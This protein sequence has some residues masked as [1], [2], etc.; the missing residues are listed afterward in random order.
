MKKSLSLAITIL[1]SNI[2]LAQNYEIDAFNGQTINTCSG[3]FYDSGGPFGFYSNNENYTITFCPTTAGSS[4]R[5]DFTNF[6]L[7]SGDQLCVFDGI[8]LAAPSF[9][10][11]SNTVPA[12]A[13]QASAT[14]ASGCLT[15]SYTSDNFDIS[16]GWAGTISCQLPC[17][18]VLSQLTSSSPVAVPL[19]DGYIDICPGKQVN[20]VGQGSYPQNNT[21]YFQQDATSTFEWS[22]EGQVYSGQNVSYAFNNPGGYKVQLSITDSLGCKSTNLLNQRVRVSEDPTF[23]G[24][25]S[26]KNTMCIGDTLTLTGEVTPAIQT[27]A[28]PLS[29]G[30]SIFLPDGVGTCYQTTLTFNDFNPGQTLTSLSDLIDI[31]VT[32][33][34]SYLGDLNLSIECPNGNIVN[35]HQYSGGGGTFLGEPIDIDTDLSPGLGYQYCFTPTSTQTWTQAVNV[36]NTVNVNGNPTLP[37]GNYASSQS[38]S[39]L[40]GCPLN[41]TWEIEICDNLAIDNGYIFSWGIQL[42]PSVYPALD[43][44]APPITNQQWILDPSSIIANQGDT[45]VTVVPNAPGTLSYDFL[46]TNSFGCDYDTTI[47]VTILPFTDPACFDCDTL[48]LP[49]LVDTTICRADSASLNAT[50]T[51]NF[52]NLTYGFY[53]SSV[54]PTNSFLDAP[55]PVSGVG[56]TTVNA[57]TIV[58]VC[59]DIT[60]LVASDIDMWLVAPNGAV[61]ELSTDNGLAGGSNY[62]NTCFTA[63]ATSNITSGSPPFTGSFQPEGSWSTLFGSAINGTWFLRVSDDAA[64]FNGILNSVEITFTNPYNVNY[65]WSPTNGLSCSN[66]PNPNASPDSTTTYIVTAVDNLGCLERDTVTISVIQAAA[67][68][69]ITCNS[70]SATSVEVSW[71]AVTNTA[72]YEVNINNGGW[73]PANGTLI[74]T[75]TGL[76]PSTTV[77]IQV[78]GIRSGICPLSSPA[79]T[80]SCTS[81]ACDLS[82][83]LDSVQNVSCFGGNNG[84]AYVNA[85]SS[86]PSLSYFYNGVNNNTGIFTNLDSSIHTILVTD[87]YGCQDSIPVTITE[88]TDVTLSTAFTPVICHGDST[89]TATATASG[90]VGNYTYQWNTTPIQTTAIATN[91]SIGTYTVTVADG[92]NCIET[93]SVTITEP[94]AL[95]ISLDKED[96]LCFG[97]ND[98][99]AWTTVSGGIAPYNYTWNTTPTQSIDT[100]FNLLKGFHTVTAMDANNCIIIDSIL[101]DEPNLLVISLD[102][103]DVSCFNAMDG[104]ITS[105][106]VGG[107]MPYRYAW[108]TAPIQ[109]STAII[110]ISGGNYALMVTD[111]NGCIANQSIIVNEPTE[112]LATFT[113]TQVTC[114]G[115]SDGDATVF[116]TGGVGGYTYE[117]FTTP[118]QTTVQALNLPANGTSVRITDSD[119]C[120]N[121]QT[122]NVFGPVLVDIDSI[123]STPSTCYES[124]NGSVGSFSSGGTGNVS[125]DWSN[126]GSGNYQFNLLGGQYTLTVT[127]FVGCQAI[128][129]I[130]V[131]RPD[132]LAI[133]FNES[134]LLC[135]GDGTGAATANVT[136]GTLPYLYNW[137]AIAGTNTNSINNLDAGVYEIIIT[138]AQNCVQRDTAIL[139]EPTPL[140]AAM[141]YDSVTC[142]N[143]NDGKIFVTASG[144]TGNYTYAW[145]GNPNITDTL[146]NIAGGNY[147][148]IVS[149][150]NNCQVTAVETVFEPLLLTAN[151]ISVPPSCTG[152]TNGMA[153]VIPIGGNEGYSYTWNTTP[154]QTNDTAINLAGGNYIFTITDIK[155]CTY[156]DTVPVIEPLPLVSS[157]NGTNINCYQI[158]DGTAT[159]TPSDGTAPY[160]YN[161]NTTT[162]TDSFV[163]ALDT[164]WH[165]VTIT[166]A[167]G[168]LTTDS[169]YLIEPPVLSVSFTSTPVSCHDGSD[170]TGTATVI[171]GVGPYSYLW[172]NGNIIPIGSGLSA[173]W[174]TV[175]ITDANNCTLIDSVNISEP[176]P[177]NVTFTATEVDCYSNSTGSAQVTPTGGVGNYTYQWNTSPIQTVFNPTNLPAG[178]HTVT[179][180]DGNGCTIVDSVEVIQ[181]N[182][183]I[184][185]TFVTNSPS[186]NGFTDGSA[187]AIATGGTPGFGGYTYLWNTGQPSPTTSGIGAGTFTVTVTDS[188]GC[189]FVNAVTIIEPTPIAVVTSQQGA[190]CYGKNDASAF[191]AASGGTPDANNQYTY[192]WSTIP[193]QQGQQATNL[194]GGQTYAVTITDE[195][196]CVLIENITINHPAPLVALPTVTN[197]LCNESADGTGTITPN[198]GTPPYQYQWDANANNQTTATATG[199]DVG[200]YNVTLTDFRGCTKD[201]FITITEPSPLVTSIISTDNICKNANDGAITVLIAGG[202]PWYKYDWDVAGLADTSTVENLFAGIYTV[203]VTDGNGCEIIETITITEPKDGISATYNIDDVSCFGERDGQIQINASGDT[204]PF[205]FSRDGV[206]Y[207]NSNVLIGLFAGDYEVFVRDNLGCIFKDTVNVAQ[208]DELIVDLG[209][210]IFLMMGEKTPIVPTIQNGT[211]PYFYNW[212][213]ND[214]TLSCFNCPVPVVERLQFDQEYT[215]L[216]TDANGC[217]GM[218]RIFVRVQK[219]RNIYVATGFSPNGDGTN[220]FLYVQGD[221]FA[222]RVVLFEVF[223]RWGEK[224]FKSENHV[225]NEAE[226]GWNG[227]LKNQTMDSGVFGWRLVVEFSDGETQQFEGSSTL[228]R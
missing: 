142:A 43:S 149:D 157:I 212:A 13:A 58:S 50:T 28:P 174:N 60:H 161:W 216:V 162:Q 55:I 144:G 1:L 220:D 64:G 172:G 100:A 82:I 26:T 137:S 112:I 225:L 101:V 155:N 167:S 120:S 44:F 141:D 221:E 37:S 67:A 24:T 165:F 18:T 83:A 99:K 199:L 87:A 131:V 146:F 61:M 176:T 3:V 104:S 38:L 219:E 32:M 88:P 110:N 224:V 75:V 185:I 69:V 25:F 111:T 22:I 170:G 14:N 214:S 123:F 180:T 189:T 72:S 52:D 158:M 218:D 204:P 147:T 210:D 213:P 181:P 207:D 192:L 41:G 227:L 118:V 124:T 106:V 98:G 186:C 132:S 193:V 188:R 109:D 40:I 164:G 145:S 191:A 59:V 113:T 11:F 102:S 196:N 19:I 49:T 39:G 183:P 56:G 73:I 223:D 12:S 169:V 68:P 6:Q 168:C 103:T 173:G 179:V 194:T 153:I 121:I 126:G 93:A 140:V 17:Q 94:T 197:A 133:T 77:S 166:D 138:D 71:L 65:G 48:Q 139:S 34:H 211:I 163:T 117:W 129:S 208:P 122:A 143:D 127:D 63:T 5:V 105:S 85:T 89:G 92:N 148:V 217:T 2:L 47:V 130:E 84:I 201:T 4:I 195:N 20:F 177:L 128:D 150:S 200:V 45:I 171:G 74:H 10:C 97:A 42:D 152:D 228:I 115:L 70:S 187:T 30:D 222:E 156:T 114:F 16:Q 36:G 66:C 31:C 9:G 125:Y 215:L 96:A 33:E 76:L 108:N 209:E 81:L 27:F 134:N 202:T 8:N 135:N 205:E 159:V 46:V 15:F 226:L 151:T 182:A 7:G 29:R 184:T 78:R 206:N 23:A 107:T 95:T 90:G 136:G 86:A 198:G 154:I 190:S 21:N 57:N 62:T 116:P 79:V 51:T 80:V 54:I 119:G 178:F 175:T 53:G 203:T 91:L 160:F 35:L